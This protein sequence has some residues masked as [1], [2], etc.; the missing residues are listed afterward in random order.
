VLPG[1]QSTVFFLLLVVAF[2]VAIWRA[3][4]SRRI[5]LHVLAGILAFLPAM[6]F[7]A[8]RAWR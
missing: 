8:A 2:A 5:A 6:L 1:P 7:G 4:V 3:V